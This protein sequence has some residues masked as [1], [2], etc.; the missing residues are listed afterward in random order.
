MIG[1]ALNDAEVGEPVRFIGREDDEPLG[2]FMAPAEN[3]AAAQRIRERLDRLTDDL[4]TD[5][6]DKIGRAAT[7]GLGV[8][9][10]SS[11]DHDIVGD[12]REA[13]RMV[14]A[15]HDPDPVMRLEMEPRFAESFV[16]WVGEQPVSDDPPWRNPMAAMLG[17]PIVPNPDLVPGGWR[18]VT[19]AGLVTKQG[20]MTARTGALNTGSI[21]DPITGDW[22]VCVSMPADIDLN[23]GYDP[24]ERRGRIVD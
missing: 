14:E 8:A 9:A 19:R 1:F 17:I 10:W 6:N 22:W 21:V 24:V 5:A 11:V 18:F 4:I 23:V 3:V 2:E 7:T 15:M 16:R 12:I 20:I 13:A